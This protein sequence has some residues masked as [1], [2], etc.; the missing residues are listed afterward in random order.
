LSRLLK[1]SIK[2]EDTTQRGTRTKGLK[3]REV[4]QLVGIDQ[5]LISKFESGIRRPTKEQ[6]KLAI[7]LE[8]DFESIMVLVKRDY[9]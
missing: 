2:Y 5:A 8:I 6:V 9:S 7:L 1:S 3:K 4:A